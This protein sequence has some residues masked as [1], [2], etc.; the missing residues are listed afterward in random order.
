MTSFVHF[1]TR[2]HWSC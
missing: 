2:A 1:V